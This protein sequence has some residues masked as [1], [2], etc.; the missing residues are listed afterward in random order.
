MK[1]K[2]FIRKNFG[3][4]NLFEIN[5]NVNFCRTHGGAKPT[6]PFKR[7]LALVLAALAWF[8]N[9]VQAPVIARPTVEIVSPA[10]GATYTAGSYVTVV[11]RATATTEVRTVKLYANSAGHGKAH[12]LVQ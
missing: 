11:A 12:T 7:V 1:Q 8:S 2:N 9:G 4:I 3:K 5:I 10:P 6:L